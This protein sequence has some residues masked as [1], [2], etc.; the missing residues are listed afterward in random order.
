[1]TL[2]MEW[3]GFTAAVLTTVA[4]V[5]Q[6]VRT[7]HMGGRELSWAMLALFGTGVSLWFAYGVLRQSWPLMIGNG[8]TLVQVAAMAMIKLRMRS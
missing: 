1:M 4:F 8:L 5:P 3:I 6:V 7:W 2:D